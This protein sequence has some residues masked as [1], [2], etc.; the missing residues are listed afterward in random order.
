M[1]YLF[2]YSFGIYREK[3]IFNIYK[4]A[5]KAANGLFLF[6]PMRKCSAHISSLI[7]LHSRIYFWTSP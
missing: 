3:K 4:K 2:V 1:Y 6:K 5:I 7:C